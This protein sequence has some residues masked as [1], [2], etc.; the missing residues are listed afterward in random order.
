MR[1]ASR[2]DVEV[3][4]TSFDDLNVGDWVQLTDLDYEQV[5]FKKSQGS[6]QPG[7]FGL[8][9]VLLSNGSYIVMDNGTGTGRPDVLVLSDI[10]KFVV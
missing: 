4:S 5:I 10:T 9:L 2:L 1:I 8:G 6:T 7:D 3:T